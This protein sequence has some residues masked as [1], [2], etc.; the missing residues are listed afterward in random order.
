MQE[1]FV[2][3]HPMNFMAF[4]CLESSRLA[5]MRV[6]VGSAAL[7]AAGFAQ[8]QSTETVLHSFTGGADGGFPVAGLIFGTDGALY[9][10]TAEGRGF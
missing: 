6:M 2:E 4:P 5:L 1:V 9:G 3:D 7:V 10:T 8:A